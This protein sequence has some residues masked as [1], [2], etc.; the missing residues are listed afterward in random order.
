M[1]AY[2]YTFHSVS[3]K[4]GSGQWGGGGLQVTIDSVSPLRQSAAAPK[5]T[6]R[7]ACG[8]RA[9][10]I[11]GPACH[12]A[13]TVEE[14]PPPAPPQCE[15]VPEPHA[16]AAARRDAPQPVMSP[17]PRMRRESWMSLTWMV[18]RL[19]CSAHRFASSNRPTRYDSDA[20]CSASSATPFQRISRFVYAWVTS[21][22]CG[23]GGGVRGGGA[24]CRRRRRRRLLQRV[25]GRGVRAAVAQRGCGAVGPQRR[26]GGPRS[27]AAHAAHPQPAAS[28]PP[29][30]APGAQRA[31]GG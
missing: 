10:A 26:G 2:P 24:A 22:T 9:R 4:D 18:T 11:G 3:T 31:A 14:S 27:R 5:L 7:A 15:H 20:S 19:P 25:H 17:R 1:H 21:R 16:A 8:K 29:A 28:H 12:K 30:H 13:R 23:G 6:A